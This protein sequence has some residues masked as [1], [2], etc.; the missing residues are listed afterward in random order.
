[1]GR[2]FK[3]MALKLLTHKFVPPKVTVDI[4]THPFF[5]T[6]PFYLL[7]TPFKKF[8]SLSVLNGGWGSYYALHTAEN[9]GKRIFSS[10]FLLKSLVILPGLIHDTF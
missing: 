2:L 6:S 5:D 8:K 7:F 10:I 3:F 1:M 4:F 9:F